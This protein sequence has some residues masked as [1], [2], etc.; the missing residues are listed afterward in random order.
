MILV[1][2]DLR[3]YLCS[4]GE[5]LL[6]RIGHDCTNSQQ[7]RNHTY[8]SPYSSIYLSSNFR[9]AH[10]FHLRECQLPV[11][12]ALRGSSPLK[13]FH[14]STV[15][16]LHFVFPYLHSCIYTAALAAPYPFLSKEM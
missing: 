1:L 14:S 3:P 12:G 16:V 7:H 13:V 2:R 4:V 15:N 11:H 9:Y 10:G 5:Q 8:K 6:S